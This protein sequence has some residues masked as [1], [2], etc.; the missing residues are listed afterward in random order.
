MGNL[1]SQPLGRSAFYALRA[2][3]VVSSGTL[4]WG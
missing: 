3:G 4:L 2:P 1:D